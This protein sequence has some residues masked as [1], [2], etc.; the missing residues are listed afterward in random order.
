MGKDVAGGGKD[1]ESTLTSLAALKGTK[2]SVSYARR[3]ALFN[4]SVAR[5][6]ARNL[7][8]GGAL[9][10]RMIG[11]AAA[12]IE[13]MSHESLSDP[14][15]MTMQRCVKGNSLAHQYEPNQP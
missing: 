14:K 13:P 9:A 10:K 7:Q 15:Y 2:E 8:G 5:A 12:M 11:K 4:A 1:G 3:E 6:A